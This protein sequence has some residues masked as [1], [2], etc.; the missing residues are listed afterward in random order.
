MARD[1]YRPASGRII[2][3]QLSGAAGRHAR[4]G[5]LTDAEKAAGAE[6]LREIIAGRDD[7]PVLLAEVAGI[8]LGANESW[9]PEYQAKAHAVAELCRLAGADE[10]LI[11]QWVQT[12]RERAGR[13]RKV[14][15]SELPQR[16]G[17]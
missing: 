3:A 17:R 13:A 9:M 12:G 1:H 11:P 6:E 2:I 4:W 15:H 8:M 5:G 16:P 10:D 7:G 14:P